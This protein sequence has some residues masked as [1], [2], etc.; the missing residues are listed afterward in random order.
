MDND[1]DSTKV[2]RKIRGQLLLCFPAPAGKQTNA[3]RSNGVA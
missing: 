3:H 2:E 1:F